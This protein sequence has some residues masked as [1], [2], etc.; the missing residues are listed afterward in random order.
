MAEKTPL[1]KK[2]LEEIL[3]RKLAPINSTLIELQRAIEF[4]NHQYELMKKANEITNRE[5][6]NLK[7]ENKLMKTELLRL[8]NCS[9]LQQEAI[10]EMEQYSRRECLEIRGVTEDP[11][12]EV[13]TNDIVMKVGSLMGVD[14]DEDDISTSHRLPKS[15]H[16]D[17]PP[18]IIAKF[19]RRDIRDRF[20]RN[21]KNL[22]TKSAK[23]IDASLPQ[24]KIY[25]SESLTKKNRDL[26]H[27][28]VQVKKNLQ[29][30]FIWSHYGKIYLRKDNSCRLKLITCQNDLDALC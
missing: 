17:A 5:M 27:K 1:T 10:N 22:K 30:K 16:S 14:L 15:R 18:A 11:N 2:V 4:I 21:R 23:D 13:D 6:E 20:Y 8:S 24:Y 19:V 3:D 28:A 9:K 26:F 7:T 25:I 29:Y 12:W